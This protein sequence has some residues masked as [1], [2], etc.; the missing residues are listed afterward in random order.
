MPDGVRSIFFMAL[1]SLKNVSLSYGGKPLLDDAELHIERGDRLCLLGV[2][3]TGK[4]SM[5]RILAGE[6]KPDRG[7][8]V[9]PPGVRVVR[10]PQEV[11]THLHGRAMDIV[12][13][14]A[15]AHSVEGVDAQQL[16]DRLEVDPDADFATLSG[17]TRRRVLLAK[18]LLGAPDVVL[19]DEP[20]NHL[21]IDS[22]AWLEEFLLRYCRT[23]LFVT[24]DRAFL[25]RMASRVVELDRGHLSDWKCDYDTFLVRKEE[26]LHAE[27]IAWANLDKKL[28]KEEAWLRQGVKARR[29][30]SVGR[31]AALMALRKERS[32]R[33]ERIGSAN[34][35]IQEAGRTGQAV[36]KAAN[37]SFGYD[38]K[39]LIRHFTTLLSR[40]DK[41]GILGPNGCGKTTLLRLMLETNTAGG[42]LVPQAGILERGTNL[43]IAYSDQL[44]AQLDE[45]ATLAENIGHGREFVVINGQRRHVIGYLQ[46]FLFE[47]ERSR[48]RVS[49]L[50]GGERNR[51]LLARLFA[52]PSNVLVLDEPTNDLDLDTLELLEEQLAE[53]SGTVLVVSHDRAFLNNVVTSTLVFEKYDISRPEVRLGE[54]EGWY[55]NEYVGGFDDWVARRAP[56]PAPPEPE[57]REPTPK[58]EP[59]PKKARM[60]KAMRLELDGLPGRIE[61][62]E[63][64]QAQIHASLTDPMAYRQPPAEIVRIQRRGEEIV[65]E[66]ETAYRRWEELEALAVAVADS[67]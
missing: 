32:Q 27:E 56:P 42:G 23:F 35:M 9:R 55:V 61:A 25:R 10:L 45:E 3:G 24:H 17:G 37:V 13:P 44:R 29:T 63:A 11:P 38:G 7:E 34:L 14:G 60:T 21:D 15:D 62:L 28:A 58:R 6:A 66:L 16:L 49:S 19:L 40:G 26:A 1:L 43:Q 2:N 22:I 57:K 54:G 65:V 59:A 20:T 51:L 46:D 64:E 52:E 36:L 47:P 31:V 5:L 50:S 33:R 41:V 18:T 39:P 30:R 53:Y 12:C 48:Q 4:S 67:Q 8:V